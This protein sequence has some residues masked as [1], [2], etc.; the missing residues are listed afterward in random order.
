MT[1]LPLTTAPVLI[2]RLAAT[3]PQTFSPV[4]GLMAWIPPSPRAADQQ[5]Q[6][7]DRG[8]EGRGVRRVVG[9]A[10]R[11]GDPD[12]VAGALVERDEAVRRG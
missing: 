9:T 6:A 4:C 8:D 3:K 12:D 2:A 10:A 7:V 1:V 11:A 5:A